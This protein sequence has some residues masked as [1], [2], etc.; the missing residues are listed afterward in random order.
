MENEISFLAPF[1]SKILQEP[2]CDR[3]LWIIWKRYLVRL[4]L[5]H[6]HGIDDNMFVWMQ[7]AEGAYG[8]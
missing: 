8:L 1:F 3:Y 2:M 5:L 6:L 7:H 4:S